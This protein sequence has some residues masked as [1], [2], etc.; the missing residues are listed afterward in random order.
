M[1][2]HAKLCLVV[3]REA[4]GMRRYVHIGTGNYNPSTAKTYTDMGLL[5]AAPDIGADVT[6][7]FN[8]MTGYAQRARQDDLP[9]MAQYQRKVDS[10]MAIYDVAPQFV[11][12]IKQAMACG[13]WGWSP[14]A[15]RR[16]CP[17]P[18]RKPSRSAPFSSRPASWIDSHPPQHPPPCAQPARAVFLCYF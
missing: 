6:D 8:V 1:K 11:P 3:R 13:A 10:L 18:P 9:G 2:I 16:C 4:D 12:T 7:L 5:T 14:S 17:P 15:R